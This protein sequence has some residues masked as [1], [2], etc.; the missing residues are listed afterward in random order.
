MFS[1]PTPSIAYGT[2]NPGVNLNVVKVIVVVSPSTIVTLLDE[3]L[4]E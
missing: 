1:A 2:R 3:T 4:A